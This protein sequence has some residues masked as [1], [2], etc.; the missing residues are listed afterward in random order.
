MELEAKMAEE[1][2]QVESGVSWLHDTLRARLEERAQFLKEACA[3]GIPYHEY[4]PM[5]GRHRENARMLG[6][7]AELFTEFYQA[8]EAADDELEEISDE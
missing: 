6:E 2:I 3:S 4:L 5:V 1:V 7:L 8:E